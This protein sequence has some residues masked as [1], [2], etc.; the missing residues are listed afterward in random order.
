MS[1]CRAVRVASWRLRAWPTEEL[2]R[3]ADCATQQ[4]VQDAAFVSRK[5]AELVPAIITATDAGNMAYIAKW[6][7][8]KNLADRAIDRLVEM[9]ASTPSFVAEIGGVAACSIGVLGVM[10]SAAWAVSYVLR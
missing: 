10:A 7:G 9:R 4:K 3:F 6:S 1:C 5:L 2:I 8:D